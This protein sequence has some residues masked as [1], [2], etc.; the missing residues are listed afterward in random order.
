MD[1]LERLKELLQDPN[2]LA[3]VHGT[4]RCHWIGDCD[5]KELADVLG[6]LSSVEFAELTSQQE[7][8]LSTVCE[9]IVR[10]VNGMRIDDSGKASLAKKLESFYRKLG[11]ASEVRANLLRA[12]I[13]LGNQESIQ[14]LKQLLVE[15]APVDGRATDQVL[16]SLM[17]QGHLDWN[18]LFPD[19]FEA[20]GPP[21]LSTGIIDLANYSFRVGKLRP[22]PGTNK[23][24]RLS[25]LLGQ[26]VLRLGKLEGSA[27][28]LEPGDE[29]AA[30]AYAA[31]GEQVADGIGL[32]VSL[33]DCLGLIGREESVDKLLL[34]SKV[35]HRRLRVEAAAALARIGNE[36]GRKLLIEATE[37]PATRFRAFHYAQEL[38]IDD[39]VADTNKTEAAIAESELATW[40]AEPQQFGLAPH[41]IELF[42]ESTLNWPSYSE[43]VVCRLF[44]YLYDFGDSSYSNV[45]IVGPL[46]HAFV[47]DL[48]D[49][50]PK[51]L[52][53]A[54]A[55]WQVEHPDIKQTD[56]ESQDP[57]AQADREKLLSYAATLEFTD[58]NIQFMG[59]FFGERI[60]VGTASK[61]DQVG[62]L[63]FS[64]LEYAWFP[65]GNRERPIDP[66]LAFSILKGRRFLRSFNPEI[67]EAPANPDATDEL[68]SS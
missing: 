26:V 3:N 12:L 15:D 66:N 39:Q 38:E 53:A 45:G 28:E 51:D 14:K 60:L 68:G 58:I 6:E 36:E 46:T 13:V 56:P 32:A 49:L 10:A 22:H 31:R 34:A 59:L 24:E 63:A 35:G 40:L 9:Q 25:E 64:M 2:A 30:K 5:E 8:I 4:I 42:D 55:G 11:A 61:G 52:Y 37:D 18:W 21:G 48:N 43:P 67:F 44:R 57:M 27:T 7:T 41:K 19:L 62:A 47:N 50:P 16:A 65:T 1:T 17:T 23:A 20:L 54:F 29:N 33:C